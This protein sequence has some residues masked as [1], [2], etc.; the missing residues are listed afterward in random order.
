M[1]LESTDH[2]GVPYIP[3]HGAGLQLDN[4]LQS[5]LFPHIEQDRIPNLGLLAQWPVPGVTRKQTSSEISD[6]ALLKA[7][8]LSLRKLKVERKRKKGRSG[9]FKTLAHHRTGK[10]KYTLHINQ[11]K[12]KKIEGKED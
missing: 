6:G 4:I 10:P 12:T 5:P 11:K 7:L 8:A 1:G 3:V 9:R 2:R